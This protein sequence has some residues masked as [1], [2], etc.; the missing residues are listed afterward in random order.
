MTKKFI[1]NI[2]EIAK[3]QA[4]VRD[5]SN[6]IGDVSVESGR[7]KVDAKSIMGVLSLDFSK[8]LRVSYEGS[9]ETECQKFISLVSSYE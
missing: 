1:I 9:D 6:V 3:V 8:P 7:Y 2:S 4:F 5:M